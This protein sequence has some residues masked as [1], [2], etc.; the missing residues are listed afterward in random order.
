[1]NQ[2][3][4]DM[5]YATRDSVH[6]PKKSWKQH[7]YLFVKGPVQAV[8]SV[9]AMLKPFDNSGMSASQTGTWKRW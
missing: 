2:F 1:V 8:Y 5:P 6:A 9:P 7:I 3:K 4:P